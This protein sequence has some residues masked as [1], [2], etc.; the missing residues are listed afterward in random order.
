MYLHVS[1]HWLLDVHV[2][3]HWVFVLVLTFKSP[4]STCT[5]TKSSD[6][7]LSTC[8]STYKLHLSLHWTLVLVLQS[9]LSTLTEVLLCTYPMS[10]QIIQVHVYTDIFFI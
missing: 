3:F 6:S 8:T 2:S 10:E 4:L 7:P 1:L 9:P 5:C